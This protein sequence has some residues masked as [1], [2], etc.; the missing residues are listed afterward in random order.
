MIEMNSLDSHTRLLC[1]WRKHIHPQLFASALLTL[2][3]IGVITWSTPRVSAMDDVEVP[4]AIVVQTELP[5]EM[6]NLKVDEAATAETG[7]MT[8]SVSAPVKEPTPTRTPLPAYMTQTGHLMDGVM[9]GTML[10]LVI[11]LLGALST[12]R[13]K[14][15]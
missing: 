8:A 13:T 12:M 7:Q 15:K 11:V 2:A 5:V 3:F 14:K 1:W 10:V 9:I 4:T 6:M